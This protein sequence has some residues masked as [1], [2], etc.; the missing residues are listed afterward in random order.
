MKIDTP[1]TAWRLLFAA[2]AVVTALFL[3]LQAAEA[4]TLH[5]TDDAGVFLG[6]K[7]AKKTFGSSQTLVVSTQGAGQEVYLKFDT[8]T[9]PPGTAIDAA[10]LRLWVT[11][12]KAPGDIEIYLV[13]DPW[14]EDTIT[15]DNAPTGR[16]DVDGGAV[17]ISEADANDFVTIDLTAEVQAWIDNPAENHGIVLAAPGGSAVNV[18]F[19]SKENVRTGHQPELEVATSY[20][21]G[22]GE[23]LRNLRLVKANA[24]V[25]AG[26]R[27]GVF[28][29]CDTGETV[30]SGGWL[31]QNIDI[32]GNRPSFSA[33]PPSWIA[34]FFNKTDAAIPVTVWA[35]CGTL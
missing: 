35:I 32:E 29:E 1:F 11:K 12:V 22:P 4:G 14:D 18:A 15:R 30:V 8:S 34:D 27:R 28:A 7:K 2:A 3:P 13:L 20:L 5:A 9:M 24:S 26:V 6:G 23:G 31:G 10:T 16:I 21:H 25:A 19:D 33:S 17:T